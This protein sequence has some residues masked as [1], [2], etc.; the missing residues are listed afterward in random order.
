M[1]RLA[2]ATFLILLD[3]YDELEDDVKDLKGELEDV[4]EEGSRRELKSCKRK[5]REKEEELVSSKETVDEQWTSV[6]DF[7]TAT[8]E[9]SE[10]VD[11]YILTQVVG[12]KNKMAK[13]NSE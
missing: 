13:I 4:R 12:A 8:I 6:T 10:D 3:D 9:N 7:V 1:S 11:F 5:L 2:F